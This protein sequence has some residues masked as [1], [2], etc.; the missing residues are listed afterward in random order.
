M[1]DM[2]CKLDKVLA[3]WKPEDFHQQNLGGKDPVIV[4]SL[5]VFMDFLVINSFGSLSA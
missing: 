1:N 2:K 5:S 3:E 4:R